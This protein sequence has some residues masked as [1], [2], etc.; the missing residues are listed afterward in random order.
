MTHNK[1]PG[2]STQER[3]VVANHAM[4]SLA[5]IDDSSRESLEYIKQ[6]ATKE[7]QIA[8]GTGGKRAKELCAR[9]NGIARSLWMAKTKACIA[10]TF[11]LHD[12]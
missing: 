10:Q 2:T 12:D 4:H 1:V 5:G 11:T 6:E 3:L 8:M 9:I 7:F